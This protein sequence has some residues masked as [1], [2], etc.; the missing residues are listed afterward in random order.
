MRF[1]HYV[2]ALLM[3]ITSQLNYAADDPPDYPLRDAVEYTVRDGLPNFFSKLESG[4]DVRIGYLGGSITAQ[5]GWRPK[6]LAWFQ[7]QYPEAKL[8]EINAAIGGTGSN[9]GVFRVQ[10]DVLQHKPDLLFVEFAVNDGSTA[11]ESIYRS[12]EGIVRQTRKADPTT[13]ICFVYT[14]TDKM[15]GDLQGGTF[16]RAA[17]AMEH[18]ADHYG[19]PSIHMGLEVARR[20]AAGTVIFK[21][22]QPETEEEKA[23]LEGKVLFSKDGVHPYPEGGHVLYLEAVIR[24]M[25]AIKEAGAPGPYAMADPFVADNWE[26]AKMV[27]LDQAV[28]GDG[29]VKLDPEA[30]GIARRF[31]S[32]MPA[33][34]RAKTPGSTLS[35]RFRGTH[36]AI[37][38]LLG[39]DCGQVTVRVDGGE[40]KVVPRFDAYCTYH[41]LAT[42]TLAT[43]LE[44]G[45]RTVEVT[46]HPEQPDKATILS[47]NGN[48]IDKPERFD[49][50]NWYAGAIMLL[51]D[52]V[53]Q[54]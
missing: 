47:K 31:K 36:A 50:T 40:P 53:A 39:P 42:L 49:G 38:D 45:L 30:D 17:S 28:L 9:L 8:S 20:E 3:V 5:P 22:P 1:P 43:G 24:A 48:A 18:I 2:F 29:W 14:L 6:T 54:E 33:M 46:V 37:Y 52:L 4:G 34:W 19:I 27:S 51:G 16:P 44:A 10:Q 11:P 25:S 35:F 15:L 32:K 41:R 12:M 13:D 26:Q 23:A 21:A 7:A